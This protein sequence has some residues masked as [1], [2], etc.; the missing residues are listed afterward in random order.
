[1]TLTA[2]KHIFSPTQ[3][4]CYWPLLLTVLE[5]SLIINDSILCTF[6]IV[7]ILI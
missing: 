4:S 7:L 5:T 3:I 6:F 2:R 1:M